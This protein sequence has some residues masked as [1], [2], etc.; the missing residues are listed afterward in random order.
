VIN[1]TAVL[2]SWRPPIVTGQNG[3]I[4]FYGVMVVDLHENNMT[5]FT[6]MDKTNVTIDGGFFEI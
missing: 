4:I 6:V 2:V 1:S 3:M 5:R